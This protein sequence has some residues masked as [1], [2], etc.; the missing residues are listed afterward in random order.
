LQRTQELLFALRAMPFSQA[1]AKPS[2]RL[3]QEST[4]PLKI[5]GDDFRAGNIAVSPDERRMHYIMHDKHWLV[6][7]GKAEELHLTQK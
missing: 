7:D 1:T 4:A 5:L 6:T 2:I 3:G